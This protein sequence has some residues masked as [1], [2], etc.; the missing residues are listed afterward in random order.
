MPRLLFLADTHLGFD[1]PFHPRVQ[2]RRRGIDFFNT[3]TTVLSKAKKYNVDAIIHGGDLFFRSKVPT[4]LVE[5]VFDPILDVAKGGIPI[6]LV[7]GNHE[8]SIIPRTLFTDHPNIHIF[9]EPRT[10]IQT[11][12]DL[13]IGLSGFPNIRKKSRNRFTDAVA[14]T[15]WQ[16]SHVDIRFLCLHQTFQGASIGPQNYEF[17]SGPDVIP[18]NIIPHGFSAVLTG[19]I[20]RY[21]VLNDHTDNQDRSCPVIYAGSTERTSFAEKDDLK[22]FV[23]IDII[24]PTDRKKTPITWT[25][26]PLQTRP[27][28]DLDINVDGL[29]KTDILNQ[30]QAKLIRF[31]PDGIVK[32]VLAS[33]HEDP[34][35]HISANQ[36]RDIAP[37]TMNVKTVFKF[38]E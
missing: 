35:I 12:G 18:T 5:R 28:Y 37:P 22:G 23:L 6:Y 7:P 9:D 21:Q 32:L 19:H 25:F 26:I 16:S 17:K 10:F 2:R 1:F 27:M 13:T 29:T 11:M 4:G 8:R 14:Q 24:T 31:S 36:I 3:F 15:D 34:L 30:I 20:H 38:K 33:S